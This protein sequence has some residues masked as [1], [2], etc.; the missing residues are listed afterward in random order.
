[1]EWL[2]TKDRLVRVMGDKYSRELAAANPSI[3]AGRSLGPLQ[4]RGKRHP[5]I[6]EGRSVQHPIRNPTSNASPL[7]EDVTRRGVRGIAV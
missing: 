6:R 1:M 7:G 2:P 4:G 3:C 5:Y